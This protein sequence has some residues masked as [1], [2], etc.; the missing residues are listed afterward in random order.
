M[1]LSHN[2]KIASKQCGDSSRIVHRQPVMCVGDT[3]AVAADVITVAKTAADYVIPAALCYFGYKRSNS[4][5][6]VKCG[7]KT[8]FGTRCKHKA[9]IIQ[10]KYQ[11]VEQK[12]IQCTKVPNHIRPFSDRKKAKR[13][14]IINR[15]PNFLNNNPSD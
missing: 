3:L 5:H 8:P 6:E 10:G 15:K 9:N 14:C 4:A 7:L 2:K 1:K 12:L 11:S 13:L